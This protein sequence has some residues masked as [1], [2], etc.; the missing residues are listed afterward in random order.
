MSY[1]TFSIEELARHIGMDA[2]EVKRLADAGAIPGQL[3][4]GQWRFHAAALLDW[5]QGGIHQLDERHIRNLEQAMSDGRSDRVLSTLIPPT[6]IELNLHARSKSSA[7]RELVALAD[8]TGLLY[9]RPGLIE[10]LLERESLGSTALPAGLAL[11]H[12]RRPMPYA[13]AAP[14]VCV[15]RV[16]AGVPF[17]AP[18]GRLTDL[19]VLI[20]NHDERHHLQVL[21]RVALTFQP[22]VADVIRAAESA[23]EV[24]ETIIEAEELAM[25]SAG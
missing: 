4:G 21:A 14:L 5:L 10:A 12:P 25:R 24:L 2:R 22:D 6:G 13:T 3:V 8:R 23:N 15:A 1:R 20:C 17:G 7:L 18:D 9:D 11:P 16:V 19:F